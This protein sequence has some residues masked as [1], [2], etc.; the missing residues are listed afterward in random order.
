MCLKKGLSNPKTGLL[1]EQMSTANTQNLL[2]VWNA[3]V[4]WVLLISDMRLPG[5][6]YNL[7]GCPFISE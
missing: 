2:L 7:G 3:Y 4:K 1:S 6:F 5:D